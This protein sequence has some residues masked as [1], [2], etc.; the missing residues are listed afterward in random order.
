[1]GFAL[2]HPSDAKNSEVTTRFSADLWIPGVPKQSP[3]EQHVLKIWKKKMC[4]TC[5]IL[6]VRLVVNNPCSFLSVL[7]QYVIICV[8]MYRQCEQ[9]VLVAFI[10]AHVLGYK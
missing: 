7:M 9:T 5:P 3:I 4:K 2:C 6:T 1:M 8:V 10:T